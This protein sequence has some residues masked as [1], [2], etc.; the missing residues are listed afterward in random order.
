MY[1]T[2]LKISK[3]ITSALEKEGILSPTQIQEEVIPAILE[4]RDILAQSETGS[5]KTL[6]FALPIIEKILPQRKVQAIILVPTREL[7][8]Q[9]A[10]EFEKFSHFKKLQILTIYGG[11]SINEQMRRL[12]HTDIVV[13]TPGRV[14]DLMERGDLRLDTVSYFVLDEADRMLDMG[15]IHDVERI[16]H[17]A[18]NKKQVM[19]FSAT[20]PTQIINLTRKYLHDPKKITVE[21]QKKIVFLTQYYYDIKSSDKVS[22]LVHLLK[23]EARKLVLV[24]CAT[25]RTT[26]FVAHQL[27][28][29]GISSKALNGDMTQAQRDRVIEEFKNGKIDALVATDVAARG[30]HVDD[31][32]HVYNY[33]LPTNVESY[34]HRIGRTARMG[35]EGVAISLLCDKDY[36]AF[37]QIYRQYSGKIHKLTCETFPRIKIEMH[38]HE[39]GNMR[40]QRTGF[41]GRRGPPSRGGRSSQGS[42]R[43]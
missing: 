24:F 40:G 1:F 41:S 10:K 6:G 7:A 15:F 12:P 22:L 28:K 21:P 42:R 43:Y 3:E 38:P 34:V 19:L 33:D 2:D 8:Q 25:K 36:E 20:L 23:Q 4:G 17:S 37:Q 29:S 26:T 18:K 30:I 27:Y 13:G 14:L 5:G 31:I 32:S 35:K 9:V 16:I 39:G 11:V